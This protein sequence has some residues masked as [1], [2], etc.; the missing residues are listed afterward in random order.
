MIFSEV[1]GA[2]QRI[3]SDPNVS[4]EFDFHR[5]RLETEHFF[6]RE[7]LYTSYLRIPSMKLTLSKY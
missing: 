7:K 6:F 4:N 3:D 2:F 5:I 1:T